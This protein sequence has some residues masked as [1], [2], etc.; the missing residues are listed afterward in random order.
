MEESRLLRVWKRRTSLEDDPSQILH[1]EFERGDGSPDLRPSVYEVSP[2]EVTQVVTEH[3]AAAGCQDVSVGRPHPDLRPIHEGA[4]E[5][6]PCG[7]DWFALLEER[8][9]E[10]VLDSKQDLLALIGR[11]HRCRTYGVSRAQWK[12]YVEGA[13]DSPEW[14]TFFRFAARG[15]KWKK[16]AGLRS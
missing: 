2:D 7:T 3:Y 8:H 5:A 10:L 15:A 9:R 16:H 11:P 1:A 14:R 12:A 4:V 13:R 6:T